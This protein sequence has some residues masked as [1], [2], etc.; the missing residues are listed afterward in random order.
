[1][2]ETVQKLGTGVKSFYV[3]TRNSCYRNTYIIRFTT[4]REIEARYINVILEEVN[5][6]Y[7]TEGT[8]VCASIVNLHHLASVLVSQVNLIKKGSHHRSWRNPNPQTS[9]L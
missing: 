9:N 1:M 8:I 2:I 5:R 3:S 7:S 4:K 6:W